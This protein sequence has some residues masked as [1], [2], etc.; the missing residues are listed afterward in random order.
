MNF[1]HT[2]LALT[3]I[4]S[5]ALL[6]PVLT[7]AHEGEDHGEHHKVESAPAKKISNEEALKVLDDGVK[8][9]ADAIT[10]KNRED[11]FNG[12]PTM[13][14]LHEITVGM[15]DAMKMLSENNQNLDTQKKARQDASLKQLT[16]AMDDYHAATHEK[17][18]AKSDAELKKTQGT[19]KMVHA[20]F[21][22]KQ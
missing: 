13:E 14:K 1:K 15:Q 22:T 4:T 19:L 10:E 3:A 11:L 9:M 16:K 12:G 18:A 2:M 6:Q 8:Y 7:S 21:A 20:Q 5:F 17:D